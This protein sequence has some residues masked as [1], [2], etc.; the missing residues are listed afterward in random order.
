MA[1]VCE[2]A[3][4]GDTANAAGTA[5]AVLVEPI[6][7]RQ[8]EALE[9]GV[10][11]ASRAGGGTVTVDPQSGGSSYSGNLGAACPR[12]A[13]C[14]ARP[15]VFDVFGEG[16]RLYR[17]D[18]PASAVA[19]REQG[20]GDSLPVREITVWAR[21]G[22]GPAPRG[23]LDDRGRDSFRVGGTLSVPSGTEPGIYRADIAVVVSYD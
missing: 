21:S 15:A 1:L 4:A 3:S 14:F 13:N 9:F 16:G 23:L 11:A 20:T 22:S 18:T 7:V 8:V 5:S 12:N 2:P 6:S 10:I 17:I 19:V